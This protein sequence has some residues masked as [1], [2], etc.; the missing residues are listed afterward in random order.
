VEGVFV[1][2]SGTHAFVRP[3]TEGAVVA[4]FDPAQATFASVRLAV[5]RQ[6]EPLAL[7]VQVEAPAAPMDRRALRRFLARL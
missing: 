7:L 5:R 6:T 4:V 1:E 3:F 2:G